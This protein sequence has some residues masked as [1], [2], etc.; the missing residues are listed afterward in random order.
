MGTRQELEQEAKTLK[1]LRR[2]HYKDAVIEG[3]L[4]FFC[5]PY[6]VSY[7]QEQQTEIAIIGG[8]ATLASMILCCK[9]LVAYDEVT[10]D[11]RQVRTK[12]KDLEISLY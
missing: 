4:P 8:V 6:V 3:I 5:V 7:I 1:R 12:I 9:N 2:T 10:Q 11:I